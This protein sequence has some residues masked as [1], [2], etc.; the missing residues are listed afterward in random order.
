MVA[1]LPCPS[2]IMLRSGS[3]P[4]T[5]GLS[6]VVQVISVVVASA[7]EAML[8]SLLSIRTSASTSVA[9][10]ILL[11]LGCV[12][13]KVTTSPPRTLPKRELILSRTGVESASYEITASVLDT[14]MFWL[15]P[16]MVSTALHWLISVTGA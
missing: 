14:A 13:V 12:M 4:A 16:A 11:E 2:M 3:S 1:T 15:T 9:Y 7:A 10:S 8:H 6:E 5:N